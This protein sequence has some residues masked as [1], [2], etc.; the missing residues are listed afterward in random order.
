VRESRRAER[1]AEVKAL[2]DQGLL[3]R[4]IGERMGVA[5]Q[6]VSDVLN[7]PTGERSRARKDRYRTPC[8]DC[9]EMT[10]PNGRRTSERCGPCAHL[11]SRAITRRWIFDSF[12]EWH[13]LFGVPPTSCD[14]NQHMCRARGWEHRI[15]RYERT[16][17][18][19]P[20]QTT[21]QD[22]FGTWNAAVEAMGFRPLRPDEH[23]IGRAGVT[24]RDEDQEAA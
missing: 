6:T 16:G 22:H 7:D 19:W 20:S 5:R 3:L 12:A 2:R 21:V 11:H 10:N 8:V 15:R 23:W 9:G 13:R 18:V 1:Y 4:E 17:R 14:W 24:L